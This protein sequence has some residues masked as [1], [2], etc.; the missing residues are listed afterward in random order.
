M[1]NKIV[2]DL[3]QKKNQNKRNQTEK[4]AMNSIKRNISF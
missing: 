1:R 4:G 3:V 2:I